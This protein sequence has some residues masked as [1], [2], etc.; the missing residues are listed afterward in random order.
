MGMM[1]AHGHQH[2]T[3]GHNSILEV[4]PGGEEDRCSVSESQG[5][6]YEESGKSH[7]WAQ[8]LT[9]RKMS[10]KRPMSMIIQRPHRTEKLSNEL[11]IVTRCW[12]ETITSGMKDYFRTAK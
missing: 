8:R 7:W 1:K 11:L 3:G 2:D 4:G 6:S 5:I 10:V 9:R 12:L